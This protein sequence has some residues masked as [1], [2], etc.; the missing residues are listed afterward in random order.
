[1][2]TVSDVVLILGAVGALVTVITAAVVSLRKIDTVKNEL[3][4]DVQAVHKI[5][6][7]Q[8]T[9]MLAYQKT[10]IDV[11]ISKGIHVPTDTSLLKE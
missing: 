9:D 3:K 8:R 10:L 6:N 1:V 4:E 2:V 5:V 11:L 7:Q